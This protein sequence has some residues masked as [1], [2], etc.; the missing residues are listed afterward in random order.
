MKNVVYV[1]TMNDSVYAI[2]ADAPGSTT[3]LW[4][5]NL[6][7]AV[8]SAAIP[9]LEDVNPQVGILSTPVIDVNAQVTYVGFRD[10]R[11]W[12]AS[13]PAAWIIAD[14]RS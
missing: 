7:T 4:H 3:P 13:L 12:R 11:T 5:V 2:D 8:P 6:G 1:A 14:R 9:D 10:V